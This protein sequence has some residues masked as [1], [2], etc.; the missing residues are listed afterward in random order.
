MQTSTSEASTYWPLQKSA[1]FGSWHWTSQPPSSLAKQSKSQSKLIC[2]V[3]DP[4]QQVV[5]CSMQSLGGTA[6]ESLQWM[7][8]WA[9]A[10]V[11]QSA[12][13]CRCLHSAIVG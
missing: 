13:G 3:H 11:T 6:H 9:F 2:V 12:L 4:V 7:S 10:W 5:Q 8:H 1:P